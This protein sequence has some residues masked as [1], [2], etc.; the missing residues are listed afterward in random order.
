MKPLSFEA[1]GSVHDVALPKVA[2]SEDVHLGISVQEGQGKVHYLH[3]SSRGCQLLSLTCICKKSV[4]DDE[5]SYIHASLCL[6]QS[7]G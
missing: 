4:Q 7:D 6:E 1:V 5:D 3:L 2:D